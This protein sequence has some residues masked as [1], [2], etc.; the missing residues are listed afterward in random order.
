MVLICC[1]VLVGCERNNIE[2]TFESSGQVVETTQTEAS[3]VVKSQNL[4]DTDKLIQRS[5]EY[6]EYMTPESWDETVSEERIL[7]TF[8]NMSVLIY[9]EAVSYTHLT[10]PTIYSV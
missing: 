9:V 6:I 8:D 3:K 2:D 4:Y 5:I 1:L 10:L 7:Y